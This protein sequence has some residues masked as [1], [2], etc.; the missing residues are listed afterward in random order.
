MC[1]FD[2]ETPHLHFQIVY[3][4]NMKYIVLLVIHHRFA[5]VTNFKMFI[6]S[7]ENIKKLTI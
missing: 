6:W 1:P 2:E 7:I 3:N 5:N 4:Y